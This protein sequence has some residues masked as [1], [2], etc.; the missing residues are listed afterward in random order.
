MFYIR[1]IISSSP[2]EDNLGSIKLNWMKHPS[3]PLLLLASI[4]SLEWR[5]NHGQCGGVWPDIAIESMLVRQ[6]LHIAKLWAVT[7][8]TQLGV[9]I[10]H[11]NFEIIHLYGKRCSTHRS[12]Y[13]SLVEIPLAAQSK[14]WMS[15]RSFAGIAG[16]NPSGTW[17]YVCCDCCVLLGRDL[18]VGL[19]TRPEEFYRIWCVWVWSWSLDNEEAL[20]QWGLLCSGEKWNNSLV[21]DLRHL[22]LSP[23]LFVTRLSACQVARANT[24]H[25]AG[26]QKE[27]RGF[28]CPLT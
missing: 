18:C 9:K 2:I 5:V 19:I 7:E 14:V 20:A 26:P 27:H 28:K 22:F 8:V 11:I 6:F 16:S 10:P 24:K 4:K 23:L 21:T 17:N 12:T 15:G 13:K 3:L 25:C 1:V